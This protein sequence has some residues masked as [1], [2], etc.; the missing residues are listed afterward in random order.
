MSRTPPTS[1]LPDSRYRDAAGDERL[2]AR[3]MWLQRA[4]DLWCPAGHRLS[5]TTLSLVEFTLR[6][7][8]HATRDV[9]SGSCGRCVYVVTDWK[10]EDSST[11]NLVV[12]VTSDEIRRMRRFTM[13]QK[14]TYLGLT[15]RGP[16]A[17]QAS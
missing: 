17:D 5:Q 12:E 15:P 8:H 14:L 11:F 9:R 10:G 13:Q 4:P 1:A 6:C 7:H 2:V 16:R 3:A